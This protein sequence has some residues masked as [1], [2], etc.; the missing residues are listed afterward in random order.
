MTTVATPF[1]KV[2]KNIRN[3]AWLNLILQTVIIASGGAVRLTG[4]GLGCDL[5]PQCSADSWTA[6]PELGF[7]SYIEFG[8]RT[9]TILLMAAA[10]WFVVALWKVRH[11]R[12]DLFA[13]AIGILGFT[14]IQG[15]IGGLTVIWKVN[16]WT[17]GTHYIISAALVTLAA[18]VVCRTYLST[19]Q[20][21]DAFA[22]WFIR[23]N[24]IL[25]A[26]LV[27]TVVI[28]V[29]TTG[30]GP[31]SGDAGAPRNGLNWELLTHLHAIPSY[32]ALFLSIFLTAIAVLNPETPK[33]YRN[34]IVG[35]V[36][37]I[38][39]QMVVGIIQ[40]NTS[41]P[42]LLVGI[43]MVFAAVTLAVTVNVLFYT[44]REREFIHSA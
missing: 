27:I 30:S 40:A 37:L 42:P 36:V 17:V 3:I 28:G 4:S 18:W 19:D 7:H 12:K 25:V 34:S 1:L 10:I 43:H 32:G 9:I 16:P 2:S 15:L 39:L 14:A 33:P 23:I 35:V 38:L 24:W 44:K 20:R 8:N 41:L 6:T 13:G 29:L 31:H 22:K 21:Y 11:Q 26:L 5:W